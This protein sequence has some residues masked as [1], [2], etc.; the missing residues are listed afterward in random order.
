MQRHPCKIIGGKM[1]TSLICSMHKHAVTCSILWEM[2]G[3]V[4]GE[5]V[6]ADRCEGRT[7]ETETASHN[8][9]RE[10]LTFLLRKD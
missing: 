3:K 2:A 6:R 1:L 7:P 4:M 5:S 10:L 8:V 9:L